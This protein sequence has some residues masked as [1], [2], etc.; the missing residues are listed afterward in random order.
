MNITL[1]V[2]NILVIGSCFFSYHFQAGAYKDRWKLIPVYVIMI[3][4][5]ILLSA[6]DVLLAWHDW[7]H[8]APMLLYLILAVYQIAMGVKGL[9]NV[10]EEK[11]LLRKN[12]V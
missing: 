7:E 11:K 10:R 12:P 2:L 6:L 4:N 9:L 1:W 3:S 8:Q 5:G